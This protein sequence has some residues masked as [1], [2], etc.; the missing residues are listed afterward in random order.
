MNL[1]LEGRIGLKEAASIMGISER[2]AWRILKAYR[3]QG[4]S[5]LTHGNRRRR[6]P[7]A[8]PEEQ[9]QEVI[10]L[11]RTIYAGLN[12]THFSEI[13][14]EREGIV[15][16]RSTVRNILVGN[17]L[18]S[19]VEGLRDFVNVVSGRRRKEC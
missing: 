7:N 8:M 18:N 1:V 5:A 10:H 12:H 15:L 2:Q 3:G 16:S 13:L 6:P 14:S 17:G 9:N 4:A 19:A 11:A